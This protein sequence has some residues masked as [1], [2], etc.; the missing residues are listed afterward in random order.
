LLASPAFKQGEGE[1]IDSSA[2][3]SSAG[4]RTASSDVGHSPD[5]SAGPQEDGES[6]E[7]M[8]TQLVG[9]IRDSDWLEKNPP[10]GLTLAHLAGLEKPSESAKESAEDEK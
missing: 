9:A 1:S 5:R 10:T 7:S 4:T 3:A 8:L 6:L 2:G